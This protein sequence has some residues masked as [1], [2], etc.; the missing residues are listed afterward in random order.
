MDIRSFPP[1]PFPFAV[2]GN[3]QIVLSQPLRIWVSHI[4]KRYGNIF[5]VS[6]GMECIVVINTTNPT[7]DTS[8]IRSTSFVGRPANHYFTEI[9]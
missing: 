1:G 9:F 3:I 4:K 2:V 5:S 7:L 6:L 8:I